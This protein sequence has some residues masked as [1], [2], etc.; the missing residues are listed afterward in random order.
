MCCPAVINEAK[1]VGYALVRRFST[2]SAQ[3][4]ISVPKISLKAQHQRIS[5][6]RADPLTLRFWKL[7]M[8]NFSCIPASMYYREL[9]KTSFNCTAILIPIETT[10]M[11][12]DKSLTL[13]LRLLIYKIDIMPPVGKEEKS[14]TTNFYFI[15]KKEIIIWGVRIL[16][17]RY[18]NRLNK[19]LLEVLSRKTNI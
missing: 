17:C 2:P 8:G 3:K 16:C 12:L 13:C 1:S 7:S 15:K 14:Y 10:Q 19:T 18:A 4:K 11:P 9:R 6:C 5:R